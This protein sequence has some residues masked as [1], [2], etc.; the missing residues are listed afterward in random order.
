MT[1]AIAIWNGV[2]AACWQLTRLVW[3]AFNASRNRGSS[4]S[5]SAHL[6]IFE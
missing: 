2:D 6:S 3:K 4:Q 1:A 5:S